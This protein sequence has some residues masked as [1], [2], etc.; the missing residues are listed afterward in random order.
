[1]QLDEWK[2]KGAPFDHHGHRIFH[3]VGGNPRNRPALLCIHGFP[4][5][6]WDWHAVW[7]ALV[8]RFACV[9]APDMI[10]FGFSDKPRPYPYS[11]SEQAD[12]HEALLRQLG[13]RR[14]HVLAHD[15][16]VTVAQELLARA[17]ERL[18]R[19]D[20]TLVLESICLLNGALFPESHRPTWVQRLMAGPLGPV[21][22]RF[23]DERSFGRSLS[24]VFGPDTQPSRE[25]LRALWALVSENAGHRLAPVL[26]GYIAERQ[27]HR[28]RWVGAL[29]R[30]RVPLRLVDGL[31]DPVSGAHLAAR[32]RELVPDPDVVELPGIGHYPQ[33]EAPGAV[34]DALFAFQDRVARRP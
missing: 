5:A 16:G 8:S 32:Y 9:V 2:R 28:E 7:D 34:V 26:L 3:R 21:A 20:D 23:V 14:V 17:D 22:V 15:L 31:H 33:L 24:A 29:Q 18:A 1:M 19:N 11:V 10:G 30:T 12:L 25:T 27:R 13:V 4:T 6:S